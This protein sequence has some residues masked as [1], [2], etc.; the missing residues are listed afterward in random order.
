MPQLTAA[1]KSLRE[2]AERIAADMEQGTAPWKRSWQMVKSSRFF[3][4]NVTTGANYH[5][6]NM[7]LLLQHQADKGSIHPAFLTYRQAKEL[8][9]S[10][11]EEI[12]VRKG[13]RS[14]RGFRFLQWLDMKRYMACKD[15]DELVI[16]IRTGKAMYYSQATIPILKTFSL[17]NVDQIENF[18]A[19]LLPPA[20][21]IPSFD[22]INEECQATLAASGATVV[23]GGNSCFFS[24]GTNTITMATGFDNE[25]AYW[26]T[27]FHEL[28]HWTGDAGRLDRFGNRPFESKDKNHAYEEIVAEMG[29]A[30]MCAQ[31][32]L[33][34][35]T[36]HAPYL[37]HYAELLKTEPRSLMSACKDA[38]AAV[39]YINQLKGTDVEQTSDQVSD[40]A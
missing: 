2:I 11:N 27:L 24:P 36:T 31:H 14:T 12:H 30:F 8:A 18:P 26:G 21:D 22:V 34:Y 35:D 10:R 1:D 25:E 3:P 23:I 4:F 28:V 17:F 39:T 16:E 19:D 13:A 6:I 32:G 40:A 29:A 33:A 15:N 20:S 5:G 37:A 9:A 38:E 7:L